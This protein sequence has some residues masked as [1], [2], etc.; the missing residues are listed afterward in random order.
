MNLQNKID[1]VHNMGYEFIDDVN[2]ITNWSNIHIIDTDGYKYKTGINDLLRNRIPTKIY[3]KSIYLI[4]NLKTYFLLNAP[5]CNF[6]YIDLEDVGHEVKFTCNKHKNNGIQSTSIKNFQK[7]QI[8]KT[9][10]MCY[11]CGKES[12]AISNQISDEIILN[13]CKELDIQFVEKTKL[14]SNG[15]LVIKFICNKHRDKGIQERQWDDINKAKYSCYYCFPLHKRTHEEFLK[16]LNQIPESSTYKVIGDYINDSYK[17]KCQCNICNHIWKAN[18][19]DLKRGLR[20]PNCRK[21]HG[22]ERI[23]DW[24]SKHN[25]EFLREFKFKS[26]KYKRELPFDFYL[27]N[28]NTC[29]EY[30]GAQH[31]KPINFGGF[32]LKIVKKNFNEQ[33]VRDSIKKDFCN[34]NNIILLEI[35]YWDFNNISDILT[36]ELLLKKSH[37]YF[38]VP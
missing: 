17:I 24:L 3:K 1:L 6:K 4:D 21:S 10:T 13:K 29:I 25:I 32:D 9:K 8:R 30:Q 28:Y 34:Q 18:P 15:N 33:I 38:Y 19:K 16:E 23:M 26:C 22:E 14:N 27:P 7:K 11:R 31:Y 12:G 5:N 2:S 36:Q 20:C 35:P 37:N